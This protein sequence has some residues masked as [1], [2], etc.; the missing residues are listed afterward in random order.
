MTST[1]ACCRP[2]FEQITKDLQTL[3]QESRKKPLQSV[4][5][6]PATVAQKKF[7]TSGPPAPS[8][9][10]LRVRPSTADVSGDLALPKAGQSAFRSVTEG[11]PRSRIH[12]VS[13]QDEQPPS[14]F[15]AVTKQAPPPPATAF[16]SPFAPG[17]SHQQA[18][19]QAVPS[20]KE[21]KQ[22]MAMAPKPFMPPASMM[23]ANP[24]SSQSWRSPGQ[25]RLQ[26]PDESEIDALMDQRA[27]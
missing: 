6:A 11:Q 20:L 18:T 5:S 27:Y 14:P 10:P 19:A 24:R 16:R 25:G 7:G 17:L 1:C 4:S 12:T 26:V 2:T 13:E 22:Q 15:A 23:D 21:A 8:A 3:Y 9:P